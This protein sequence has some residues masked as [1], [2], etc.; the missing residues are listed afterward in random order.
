VKNQWKPW[1][2]AGALVVFA[3]GVGGI[4]VLRTG[5]VFRSV[6]PA[7]AGECSPIVLGGSSEDILIDRQRGIAYLSLLDRDNLHPGGDELGT[8]SL[9]DLNRAEPA[10]RAAF[11]Y[12]P[13]GFRPH[14]ISLFAPDSQPARMFVISHRPDGSRT[15]EIAEEGAF[16]GFF[17]KET[18]RDDAFVNPNAIVATGARQFYVGSNAAE[19]DKWALA[20]QALLGGGHSTIVYFD[21]ANARV[22]VA[23]LNHV[24]GLALS[25]D[26]STLYVAETLARK[27]RVYRRDAATGSLAL[28][29]TIDLASA[30]GNLNVGDDGSVWIAAYPKLLSVAS[31]LR[32]RARRAPTQV[33]R[34]DPKDQQTSEIYADD[35]TA[36]SAGSSAAPWRDEFLIGALLDR[37]V[38]LCKRHP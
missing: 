37:K 25:A 38:L 17:P 4:A 28:D 21:G 26:G 11:G 15:I 9:I 3:L 30:P 6:V 31:H 5:G 34:F 22:E 19:Q 24:G 10:P 20:K 16:G 8:V 33:L 35:G 12:D 23:D 29:R 1:M 27:L 13:D 14:G 32:D 2:W 18:I 7:F 36:I